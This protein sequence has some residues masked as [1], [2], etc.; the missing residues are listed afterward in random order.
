MDLVLWGKSEDQKEEWQP[1]RFCCVL[2]RLE[3]IWPEPNCC[4]VCSLNV[5]PEPKIPEI[6]SSV[7]VFLAPLESMHGTLFCLFARS[8]EIRNDLLFFSSVVKFQRNG[9]HKE[10]RYRG[11]QEKATFS[12]SRKEKIEGKQQWELRHHRTDFAIRF[13]KFLYCFSTFFRP[14]S[15]GKYPFVVLLSYIYTVCTD[16]FCCCCFFFFGYLVVTMAC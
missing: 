14:S 1:T 10:L 3:F 6:F 12:T 9:L 15:S 2:V 8:P 7:W 16:F 11:N 4:G 5:L 13:D